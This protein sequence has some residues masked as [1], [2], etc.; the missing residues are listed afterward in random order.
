[1]SVPSWNPKEFSLYTPDG[2]VNIE[3]IAKIPSIW[4]VVIVG[5]RQVGKTYG[6]L[7]YCA[8]HD[9]V[10]TLYLR[11]TIDELELISSSPSLN[12]FLALE[13]EGI[14]CDIKKTSKKVYV[15]GDSEIENDAVKI[16]R[17]RGIGMSLSTIAQMRGFNGSQFTD[18]Y[19]DEFIPEKTVLRRKAEGDALLNAYVTINGNRELKGKPPLKMWLTANAFDIS[20]P[21][22]ASLGLQN[23]LDQMDKRG[24][25]WSIVNG[26]VFVAF[27]KSEKVIKKRKETSMMSYLRKCGA[28]STFYETAINNSF[29]YDSLDLV[30][31]KSLRGYYPYGVFGDL[32]AWDNGTSIY[33]CKSKHK[34]KL[35]FGSTPEERQ[36]ARIEA[37]EMRMLYIGGYVT[38][39]DTETLLR[40]REYFN[41]NSGNS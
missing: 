28:S 36:R 16:T 2:W 17:E 14:H 5:P 40:F 24:Q 9:N 41:I 39:S 3:G 18:V 13:D 37:C 23:K 35:R 10:R 12:P 32:Y 31:P 30:K 22:L 34:G 1:M 38:F 11:R 15:W 8:T 33:V 20:N 19:L 21:I 7:K 27:P 4:L 29:A 26:G 6:I 25:E